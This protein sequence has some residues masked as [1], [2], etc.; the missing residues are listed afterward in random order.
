MAV[1]LA[2]A[3]TEVRTL[4]DEDTAQFWTNQ[5]LTNWLN[6]GCEDIARQAQALWMQTYIPAVPYQQS[7]L[8]PPDFL[9]VHRLDYSFANSD[10]TYNLEFRGIKTMDEIWGILQQLPAAYPQA[11]Y[12]WND[13]AGPNS[14]MYFGTYPVVAAAGDFILYYYRQAV[15]A[16]LT[17]DLIDV[18]PGYEDIVYEYVIYKAKRRDRDQTWQEAK[19]LYDIQLQQMF[20]KTRRFSDQG[21]QFTSG[22]P[23][24]PIYAY[25]D[26]S[27]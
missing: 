17:T 14:S 24:W 3:L 18:T 23:Q 9:G 7:Y 5:M 22:T 16:V 6:Q 4:L 13:T 1:T 11:F 19:G 21:D 2:A 25:T 12:L 10:Q 20:D 15:P 27:W 26:T 8:L